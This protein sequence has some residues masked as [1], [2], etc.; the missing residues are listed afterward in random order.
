MRT[1]QMTI[2]EDLLAAVDK[3]VRRLRTTRSEF[4]RRALEG[5]LDEVRRLE[6][7]RRQA[8]GYKAKPVRSG[9]FGGWESE[10]VWP[11]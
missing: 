6:L 11:D 9:E 10:Q 5:A 3:V 4:T 2:D 8:R 1:V 7:E